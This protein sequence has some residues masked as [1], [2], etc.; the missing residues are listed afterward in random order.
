MPPLPPYR[1]SHRTGAYPTRR[2]AEC[3]NSILRQ[4]SALPEVRQSKRAGRARLSEKSELGRPSGSGLYFELRRCS[5]FAARR[6]YSLAVS[7]NDACACGRCAI[8]SAILR[9]S[10]ARLRQRSGSCRGSVITAVYCKETG[11]GN[12]PWSENAP[13]PGG[14]KNGPPREMAMCKM[15]HP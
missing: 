5:A 6:S 4:T 10:A 13:P 15:A 2:Q 9:I 12:A 11:G 1:Q 7:S 3:A 8:P 14:P